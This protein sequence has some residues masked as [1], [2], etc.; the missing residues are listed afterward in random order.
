MKKLLAAVALLAFVAP[1][2]AA[3]QGP[4]PAVTPVTPE[5][6]QLA[7][8]L[9]RTLNSEELTRAQIAKMLNDTLP[10][11]LA[12]NPTFAAAERQHPGITSDFLAAM[13]GVIAEGT[14][15]RLPALW[16]RL[17]P[18]FSQS[19]TTAELRTLV[20]FYTSPTGARLIKT[21][22][23][24]AD[25]S[26]MLGNMVSDGNHKVTTEDLR[27]GIQSGAA[28]VIRTATP[29]DMKTMQALAATSAGKKLLVVNQQAQ[30]EAAAWGNE[31]DPQLNAQVI[32]AVQGVF[33]KYSGKPA[34]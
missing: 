19:F 22:G 8:T 23:E 20:D 14:I 16:A 26:Q 32:K 18:I 11:T 34:Q 1:L 15:T 30:A 21:M 5:H 28:V 33:A 6:Q 7:A 13:G 9:V 3:V 27:A 31:A 24:G 10:K 29:E 17:E 2:P 4:P 25:Y 12:A